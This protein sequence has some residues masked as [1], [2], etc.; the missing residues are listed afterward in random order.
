MTFQKGNIFK[1]N[2]YGITIKSIL[3]QIKSEI[4][5]TKCVNK[6]VKESSMELG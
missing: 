3:I 2:S 5:N 6:V 1:G 4:R